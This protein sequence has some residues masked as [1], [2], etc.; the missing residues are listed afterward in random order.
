[1]LGVHTQSWG[2]GTCTQGCT[3]NLHCSEV[4]L[5]ITLEM[6]LPISRRRSRGLEAADAALW[7]GGIT[8]ALQQEQSEPSSLE[9]TKHKVKAPRAGTVQTQGRVIPAVVTAQQQGQRRHQFQLF[10]FMLSVPVHMF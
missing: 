4:H 2:A 7:G 6:P 8:A 3:I 1:M 9:T 10:C 5:F